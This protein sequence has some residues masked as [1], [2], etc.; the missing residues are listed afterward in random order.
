MPY[1][2]ILPP[3]AVNMQISSTCIYSQQKSHTVIWLDPSGCISSVF[4]WSTVGQHKGY[5]VVLLLSDC[6]SKLL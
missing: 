5:A 1:I 3:K 6:A 2:L 4:G